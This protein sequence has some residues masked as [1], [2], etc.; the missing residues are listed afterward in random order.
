MPTG[1]GL[2]DSLANGTGGAY[3]NYLH[4]DFTQ[5]R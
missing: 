5:A 1:Q 2:Y 4:H 3:D